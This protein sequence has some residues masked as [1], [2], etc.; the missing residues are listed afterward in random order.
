MRGFLLMLACAGGAP[1]MAQQP[2]SIPAPTVQVSLEEA[3][4]LALQVQ[5]AMVQ[6]RGDG[7]NASASV[8]ASNGAFLPLITLN[9]SSTRAGGTRFD[10]QRN[11]VVDLPATTAVSGGVSASMDLFAGFRRLADRRASAAT[12][13]AADAGLVNQRFQVTLQT[14]QAFYA[15]L[16]A[17]EKVLVADAQ[18]RRAQQQLQISVDKLHAGSATLSDSLRSVVEV[19][20]ARL[21]QLQAQADLAAAGAS[22]GRQIGVDQP[23]QALPDTG[24]PSLP[25]TAGLLASVRETAPQVLQAEAQTRAAQ[26]QLAVA[27]AGYWPT[28][29]ASISNSYSGIEPPWTS[30]D[31]FGRGWNVR[32]SVSFQLFDRFQREKSVT[33]ASVSRDV[34][35]AKADDARRAATAQLTQEVAA[36]HT[37]FAKL[38]ITRSNVAAATEDLRVQ[39]ERY[40][41]GAGTIL[42]VL[43]SQANLTQAQTDEVQ[44]RYDY[45]IARAQLEATVGHP[46]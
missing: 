4:R 44:A 43:T 18:L 27:R 10:N 36:L 45:L 31:T 26:A 14:K 34:A 22:L 17:G 1:A 39:Q 24:L 46:L 13:R 37:A 21:A 28:F 15:A 12:E 11:Q 5:P 7:R 20:N 23:V 8:L 32:F 42:D 6:A 2:D 19:G 40:R 29:S 33:S 16:A 30:T 41:V 38:D 25:D 35:Q 9:G 3:V